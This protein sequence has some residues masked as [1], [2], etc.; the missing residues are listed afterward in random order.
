MGEII[1]LLYLEQDIGGYY[2]IGYAFTELGA[3]DLLG[4]SPDDLDVAQ[5]GEERARHEALER[6]YDVAAQRVHRVH[7][8]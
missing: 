8:V 4:I 5:A 2:A 3:P 6:A 1:R 7:F